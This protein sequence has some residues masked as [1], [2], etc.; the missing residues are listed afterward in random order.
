VIMTARVAPL[1]WPLVFVGGI[2]GA[3]S[4]HEGDNDARRVSAGAV[5]LPKV[6]L[7][8]PGPVPLPEVEPAEPGPVPMPNDG[9][10]EQFP[11]PVPLSELEPRRR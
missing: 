9:Y 4:A 6:E 7:R 11:V 3:A 2:G 1:V 5:P 10:H 8:V